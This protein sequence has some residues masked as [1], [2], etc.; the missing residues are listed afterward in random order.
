MGSM[1]ILALIIFSSLLIIASIWHFIIH[2]PK[3]WY[4]NAAET[5]YIARDWV[6][7]ETIYP[8]E[9]KTE[10]NR[11]IGLECSSSRLQKRLQIWIKPNIYTGTIRSIKSHR[12]R[13][14]RLLTPREMSSLKPAAEY[15]INNHQGSKKHTDLNRFKF[16][17]FLSFDF[18]NDDLEK[19]H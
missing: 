13:N 18:A 6:V 3:P 5:E 14:Q 8:L 7:D 19:N 11:S 10:L 2:E 9:K 12:N 16:E 1:K 15:A 4:Y 17:R